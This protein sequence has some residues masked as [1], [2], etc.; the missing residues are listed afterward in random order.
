MKIGMLVEN[1]RSDTVV[2]GGR[3]HSLGIAC[4]LRE[5]G[6]EV[7]MITQCI[8]PF[9]DSF[10]RYYKMPKPVLTNRLDRWRGKSYQL[11]ISY[12]ILATNWCQNFAESLGVPHWAFC[13]DAE[14]LC[15]KYAPAVG[16]RMHY[17]REHTEALRKS[18]LILSISEYAVPFIKEWTGNQNVIGLMGCVN[19]A[20]AD[21]ARARFEP[22]WFVAI[23]RLTEHKRLSDLGYVAGA[24]GAKIAIITSHNAGDVKR[25]VDGWAS[26][27]VSVIA[28]PDDEEK[29]EIIKSAT[30]M[31]VPSAYEGLGMPAM[32]A[33]Y[34]GTPVVCYKFPI[35]EEVCGDGA[36]YASYQSPESLASQVTKLMKDQDLLLDMRVKAYQAGRRFSF[37]ALR[38]RLKEVFGKWV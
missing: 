4:A 8:P 22:G 16:S 37:D 18:D 11:L 23:S 33:L 34:C 28:A 5:I 24:T 15:K 21:E 30:A 12:P 25:R 13:L 17:G 14:P 3:Y 9:W 35:L 38:E 31:I 26:D 27:N 32:E 6:Y 10:A 1:I 20:L 19:S 29:Y 2:S 36:L 7:D